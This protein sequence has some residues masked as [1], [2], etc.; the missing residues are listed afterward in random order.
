VAEQQNYEFSTASANEILA[1][2]E[3]GWAGFTQFA[4]YGIVVV[5]VI[6]LLML[7][8]VA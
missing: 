4:T 2:R 1:E 5:V 3:R 7:L 6:L 8:F